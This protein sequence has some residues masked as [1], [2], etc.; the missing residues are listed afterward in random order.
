M[1]ILTFRSKHC[2]QFGE[3]KI[4]CSIF[5]GSNLNFFPFLFY[6]MPLRSSQKE[7]I[8]ILLYPIRSM[9]HKSISR[10]FQ[11]LFSLIKSMLALFFLHLPL[12]TQ[13]YLRQILLVQINYYSILCRGT[14]FF[15]HLWLLQTLQQ[16]KFLFLC[17][18]I[19]IILFHRVDFH[20]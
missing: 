17:L 11:P 6:L 20:E 15:L 2:F 4:L 9:I 7:G 1:P 18:Y 14:K 3:F 16:Q 8:L 12:L 19:L 5:G 13:R 10:A